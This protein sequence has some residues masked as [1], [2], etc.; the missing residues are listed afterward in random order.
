M[1]SCVVQDCLPRRGVHHRLS[2]AYF[3]HSNCRDELAVKTGKRLIRDH[4][5]AQGKINTDKVLRDRMQYNNT[6]IPDVRRSPAQMV[7]NL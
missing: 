4:V 1:M 6:P 7:F 2:S 3:P 5:S